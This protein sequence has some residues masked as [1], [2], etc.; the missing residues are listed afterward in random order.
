MKYL[1]IYQI[2][3]D[4]WH[5]KLGFLIARLIEKVTIFRKEYFYIHFMKVCL[6]PV[7]YIYMAC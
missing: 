5:V 3:G 6:Y 1:R 4:Y 7:I 2:K